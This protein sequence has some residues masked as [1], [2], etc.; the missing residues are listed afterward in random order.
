M[1]TKMIF[2]IKQAQLFIQ[3]GCTVVNCGL[4]RK[5]KVYIEFEVNP[6]FS[7]LLEKWDKKE[8]VLK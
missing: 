6:L 8:F 1:N 3:K 4:G 5:D 7:S 2:N